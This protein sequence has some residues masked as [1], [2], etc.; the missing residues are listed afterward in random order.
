[1]AT[2]FNARAIEALPGTGATYC[3]YD[4]GLA[5]F[6]V[7]VAAGGTRSWIVEYR[8]GGG[9]RRSPT[10]RITLGRVGTLSLM[11]ARERA[12]T[13][14]AAVQLG[15]D[16]AGD[17]IDRRSAVSV[18]ELAEAYMQ[19]EVRPLLKPRT[20][21]LYAGYINNHFLPA[22]GTRKARDVT[23]SDIAK[24]HRKIGAGGARVAANRTIALS[25]PPTP[26]PPRP[27]WC[28]KAPTLPAE[29]PGSR[30]KVASAI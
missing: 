2:R 29:F 26:G 7:R 14:L 19:E 20:A 24:L 8:P 25:A 4:P 10:K 13:I 5:G 6:G 11:Q 27:A 3:V 21:A 30:K 9:G 16:P 15:A 28:Q 1:M 23:H 22:L 17:K 12:K 18:A